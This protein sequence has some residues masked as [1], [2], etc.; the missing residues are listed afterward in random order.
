LEFR[1]HTLQNGLEIVAECNDAAHSAAIGFFVKT[2]SRDESKDVWGVSHFL[3]HMT[4]KGTP[5][6]SADDVNRQF[7]EMG[8]DVNAWT[9]E[10][11]TCYH[12]TMLPEYQQQALDILADILRPSLRTEDF[13]TEKQVIIEEIRMYDDQPPFG[14]YEKSMAAHFGDHPLGRSV[15]GTVDSITELKVDEM[16]RYFEQR[17]CPSNIALVGSGKIDFDQF[18]ADAEQR[19]GAWKPFAADRD[20]TPTKTSTG[21]HILTKESA[22]QEYVLIL[23]D[24]PEAHSP[25]RYASKVLKT[26]VGDHSGSRLYWELVEPGLAEFVQMSYYDCHGNGMIFT[27]LSC[28][29]DQASD[30]LQRVRDVFQ[31]SEADGFTAEELEQA[32]NKIKSRLVLRSER[33]ANRLMMVGS[34]WINRHSYISVQQDL[35]NF[36]AVTLDD[37]HRVLAKYPLS[38]STTMAVGPLNEIDG[39][40]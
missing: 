28:L 18:I 32:L 8:A 9:S 39:S 17:Y 7:D 14:G 19:C 22:A 11:A 37:I 5:T 15:L 24:A 23:S 12:A 35:A 2:G 1:E 40:A 4:F 31:K 3:E 20:T 6:R 36:Q 34:D 30:N 21:T 25:D 26:I 29:P 16:R 27:A 13:D 10:E 38:K 33:P